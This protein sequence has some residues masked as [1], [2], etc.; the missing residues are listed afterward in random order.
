MTDWAQ[1]WVLIHEKTQLTEVGGMR[2]GVAVWWI[3]HP[4]R[5]QRAFHFFMEVCAEVFL[6][7]IHCGTMAIGI[8]SPFMVKTF[9]YLFKMQMI[10][11]IFC[12][13]LSALA[14]TKQCLSWF[15]PPFAFNANRT[16]SVQNNIANSQVGCN[17]GPL[18]N[19][20]LITPEIPYS[21]EP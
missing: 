8:E 3:N 9:Q 16:T 15:S 13:A 18:K 12:H 14:N 5:Y 19:F 21:R 6:S 20:P 11:I 7:P 2:V 1:V 17:H 10:S 4:I